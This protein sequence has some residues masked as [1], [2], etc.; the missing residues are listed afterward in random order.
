MKAGE[1]LADLH[2][3]YEKQQEYSLEKIAKKEKLDWRLGKKCASAG[4]SEANL[5]IL[6]PPPVAPVIP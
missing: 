3:N 4:G 1:R 6:A 2:L 5:T